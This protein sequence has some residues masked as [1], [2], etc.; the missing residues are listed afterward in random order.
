MK[1]RQSYGGIQESHIAKLKEDITNVERVTAGYKHTSVYK[2]D[3]NVYTFGEGENGELGNGENFSYYV[4]QLV[5]KDIIQTNTNNIV[6]K[7]TETY[8]IEG[9]INY[10]NLFKEKTAELT[11]E[12]VD[13]NLGY[14][15]S[16]TGELMAI[17]AGRTTV[18][19]REVGTEKRG[20]IQVDIEEKAKIEPKVETNGSHTVMLRVDGTVW[21][22]GKGTY[23]ELGN[24]KEE[25]TDE[26]VKAIFPEGTKIVEVAAGE[27]HSVAL[28]EEG[29]VWT[30]GRNNYYQL[31]NNKDT[32]IVTPTKVSGLRGI[33]KIA[34][35]NNTTYAVGEAGEIY[36]FG[37]NANGEGGIRKLYKQNRNKTSQKHNR[38]N[39]HKSRK[40]PCSSI[41]EQWRSICNRLKPIW[42]TRTK[43]YK[44]KKDR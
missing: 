7:K 23:G 33:K 25:T 14:I 10:F 24:G 41:K 21:S 3:G 32:N 18:I 5:G 43:Q 39:R 17:E 44:Y 11:Y 9:W 15:D 22:F 6:L 27:N 40:E 38:C 8:D 31:G 35:G 4:P 13:S 26:P 19:V 34:A 36:S 2:E 37:L 29:N 1:V 28:D 30:W 12:I 42:R 16:Q 20:V